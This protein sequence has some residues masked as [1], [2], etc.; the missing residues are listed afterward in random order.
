MERA[1][2]SEP[3]TSTTRDVD[4]KLVHKCGVCVSKKIILFLHFGNMQFDTPKD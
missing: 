3:S 1:K 2:R 4:Q